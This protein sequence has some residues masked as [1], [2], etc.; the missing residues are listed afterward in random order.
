MSTR[1]ARFLFVALFMIATGSYAQRVVKGQAD[2]S[3]HNFETEGA[4]S[5]SGEWEFYWNRLLTPGDFTVD[6]HPE[7]LWPYAWNRQGEHPAIGC[8]TY[9]LRLKFPEHHPDLSFFILA[10]NAAGKI[11]MNNELVLES[12]K[13]S[14]TKDG[15]VAKLGNSVF[16]IPEDA[17]QI[18]LVIQIS[19]W[20]YFSGGFAG[21]PRINTSEAMFAERNRTNGVE[22]FFSG[23]LVA[24]FIYQ[25]I[26][27]F[28]YHRGKPHLWLAL[29]CLGVALR[30]LIVHGGSFLLP[31]LFPEVPFEVWKKIEFGSVYLIVAWF[32]LYVYHLFI[33]HAP[34]KPLYILLGISA[35]IF[36]PVLFTPQYLYGQLL[37]IAHL[38]LLLSFIYAVYSI[39]KAWRGGNKDARV[40]LFGVLSSFPF[41]LAEILKNSQL[42]PFNI[43]FMYL[44]E[45]GVLVFLLFQVYLLANH[46]ANAY[47][48]LETM[49]QNLEKTIDERTKQL[50]ATN[51]VKDRLLSVI[52]HDVKSPLNS[53]RGVLNIYNKGAISKD[54]F[55]QLTLQIEN[56]L[57]KTNMLVE[58]IL[59]WTASQLKGVSLK[60]ENFDLYAL[61]EDNIR[62]FD[63]FSVRKKIS[64]HHNVLPQTRI[65]SDRNILN[66][67]L[68]NLLS[69]ALKFSF[70]RGK[71]T[72]D[73]RLNHDW[74]E[75]SVKDE[76]TGMDAEKL[77][78]LLS[79]K[80]TVSTTG[81]DNEQGTGL[82]LALCRDYVQKAGG[83]LSV[84][85]TVGKGTT[86]KVTLPL[87]N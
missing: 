5:L 58:N 75:L 33:E 24:M 27:Y 7:Y 42:L 37:E 52:S 31:N 46:Y 41:I 9:R 11:W 15:H 62:L 81:T 72:I 12:G 13:V 82:G 47:R 57:G 18:E 69:N 65:T 48:N 20:T 79:P 63:T 3:S 73:V 51:T 56:D 66:L 80:F 10:F 1:L 34:K 25:L 74:L 68:R 83:N 22:N 29:I 61:V 36:L 2:L 76:G 49:N 78:S 26:L 45:I 17:Q 43:G 21:M 8:A 67:V 39:T 84:E 14:A 23:S 50:V 59:H 60:L 71:I 87:K 38:G 4:V 44:V 16:T 35:G 85:S 54:E 64:I 86:F 30:A 77:S 28:L 70:E 55:S 32:P 40:I 19:N 6:Q 53:L